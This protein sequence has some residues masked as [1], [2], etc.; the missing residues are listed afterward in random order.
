MQ[1][2]VFAYLYIENIVAFCCFQR[3]LLSF[4]YR[5]TF[6]RNAKSA[7]IVQKVKEKI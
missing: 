3:K 2:G 5:P 6:W 4:D 7:S 1:T